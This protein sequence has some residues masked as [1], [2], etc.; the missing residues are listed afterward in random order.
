[1]SFFEIIVIFLVSLF[2]VKPEDAKHILKQ[3]RNFKKASNKFFSSLAIPS[4]FT[5]EIKANDQ[6]HK[7]FDDEAEQVNLYLKKILRL[8]HEYDGEYSLENVKSF[9]ESIIRKNT[10]KKLDKNNVG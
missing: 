10:K 4:L 7:L 8:G 5:E 1:M 6:E 3:F 2:L 9:Y